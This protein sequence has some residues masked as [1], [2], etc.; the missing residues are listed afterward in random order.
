M[1]IRLRARC[2]LVSSLTLTALLLAARALALDLAPL[3]KPVTSFGAAATASHLYLFGGHHGT[4]HKY[5]RATT[6]GTLWQAPL[7]G[8]RVDGG[9]REAHH[10]GRELGGA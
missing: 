4:A 7:A 9:R 1:K 3:P 10:A 2:H 8:G 5:H 6:L